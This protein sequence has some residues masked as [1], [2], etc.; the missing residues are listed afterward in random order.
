MIEALRVHNIFWNDFLPPCDMN[1]NDK[2][3][4]TLTDETKQYDDCNIAESTP[5]EIHGCGDAFAEI[6]D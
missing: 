5:S 3:G 6:A 2:K 1:D 4:T